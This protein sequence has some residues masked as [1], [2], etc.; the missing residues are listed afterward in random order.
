MLSCR[1]VQAN[2]TAW[3]DGELS[4]RWGNRMQTHLANC[5]PC[6]AEAESLQAAIEAHRHLLSRVMVPEGVALDRLGAQLQ[7]RIAADGDRREWG[8][9]WLF[10]RLA[11]AG[12]AVAAAVVLLV[13]MAGGPRAVLI[14][15]G[16]ESPPPAVTREPELF[17]DYLL[18]QHLDALENFDSVESVPLEEEQTTQ[19]G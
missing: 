2:L 5:A 8:W 7:R 11:L 17:K 15:L 14:P 3:L 1:A 12:G 9:D 16:V 19:S 10:G 18:I 6:A 13:W 4:S